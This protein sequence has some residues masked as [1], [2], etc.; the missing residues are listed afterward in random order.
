MSVV[1]SLIGIRGGAPVEDGFYAYL[2]SDKSHLE[3]LFSIF[4]R[5]RPSTSQTSWGPGKLPLD[6]LA[7]DHHSEIIVL[8]SESTIHRMGALQS[9]PTGTRPTHNAFGPMHQ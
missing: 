6:G 3:Q 4:E 8:M 9:G 5:C 1:S 7:V 2:R